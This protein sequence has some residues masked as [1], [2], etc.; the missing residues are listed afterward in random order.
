[1]EHILNFLKNEIVIQAIGFVGMG[2]SLLSVQNRSYNRVILCKI[3]AYLIFGFQF[4][5][6]GA[7]TGTI[8]NLV[9]CFTNSVYRYRIKKG[10]S[11]LP[12]Q[13][14]FALLFVVIGIATWSGP[15]SL[16]VILA[17]L[18]STISY[19]I[20]N[21]KIIRRMTLVTMPMWLCYDLYVFSIG[22]AIN[23]VLLILSAITAIIRIDLLPKWKAHKKDHTSGT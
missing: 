17:K 20:K 13:I 10:K 5:L 15:I 22:G 21:T 6:L 9:S 12:C 14:A 1:M 2:F 16:L 18:L 23:D 4:F 19:G 8:T 11:T 7:Y 3:C